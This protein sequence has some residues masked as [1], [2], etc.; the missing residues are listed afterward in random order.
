MLNQT[1]EVRN[2]RGTTSQEDVVDIIELPGSEEELQRARNLL[3]DS[4]FERL[5]NLTVV[6]IW[7]TTLFLGKTSFLDRQ[8]IAALDF[9]G[10]LLAAE[11]L[12]AG[13]DG[14]TVVQH[15][16]RGH[17][18]A[19]I[20]HRDGQLIVTAT[21]L[22][23][24][25]TVSALEGIGLDIDHFRGKPGEREG[26]FADLHVF[27][28]AC[29]Q[30]HLNPLGVTRRRA[31]NFEI[32]GDFFQRV[33]DVLVSLDLQLVFQVILGKAGFHFD[34]FGDDRR[35]SHSN[36]GR[37]DPA[38]GLGQHAR[39]RLTDPLQLGDVLLY[40][41]VRWKRLDGISLYLVAA[42]RA[43]QFEELD[44]SRADIDPQ[45]RIRFLSEEP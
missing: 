4:F 36:R 5:Q 8:A 31:L 20:H 37:L 30:Q 26:C 2:G 16:E 6:V 34:G 11:K 19:N 24:Q 9:L 29:G 43:T 23:L 40:H 10:Q 17:R 22:R 28:A 41:C 14:T 7:K 25:Q 38:L 12:L 45:Q 39:E 35:T 13:V 3:N 33:G 21:Q 1:I 27:L 44:R 32:D 18:R 42:S 15:T